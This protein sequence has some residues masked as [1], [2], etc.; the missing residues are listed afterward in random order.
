[1]KKNDEVNKSR[2]NNGRTPSNDSVIPHEL[3]ECWSFVRTG[4]AEPS[5]WNEATVS[6][7]HYAAPLTKELNTTS[8]PEFAAKVASV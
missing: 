2:H 7:S 8:T 5:G 3:V 4:W 1:M 6:I